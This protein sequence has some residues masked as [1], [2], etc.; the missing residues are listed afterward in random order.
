MGEHA[1]GIM[2]EAVPL[3]QKIIATM[4]TDFL[5]RFAVRDADLRHVRRVDDQLTAVGEHRFEFVHRFAARPDLLIHLGRAGEDRVEWPLLVHEVTL[6]RQIARAVPC[7]FRRPGKQP[8]QPRPF[9][10]HAKAELGH[11]DQ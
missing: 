1:P 9:H 7:A 4:V 8:G 5:N 3:L 10:D 6:P 11:V 2:L